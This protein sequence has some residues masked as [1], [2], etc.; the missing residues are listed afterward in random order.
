MMFPL[1]S[2]KE[3]FRAVVYGFDDTISIGV[4]DIF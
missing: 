3:R 2:S 4:E 1:C